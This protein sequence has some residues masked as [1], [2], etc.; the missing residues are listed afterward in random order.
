MRF[1]FFIPVALAAALGA[2]RDASACSPPFLSFSSYPLSGSSYPA[3]AALR[4]DSYESDFDLDDF[5]VLV[6]DR[7]ARLVSAESLFPT[8]EP[9]LSFPAPS[10]ALVSPEP[11]PGQ[12]VV[13]RGNVCGALTLEDPDNRCPLV[14][15][16]YTATEPDTAPPA[17]PDFTYTFEYDSGC[18]GGDHWGYVVHVPPPRESAVAAPVIYLLEGFADATLTNRKFA[19]THASTSERSV[20][21]LGSASEGVTCVRVRAV[22]LAGHEAGSPSITCDLPPA[23]QTESKGDDDDDDAGKAAH[24]QGRLEDPGACQLPAGGPGA[25]STLWA[26]LLAASALVGGALRRR[27]ARAPQA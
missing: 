10:A 6:N 19:A 8:D 9:R 18:N 7:P 13:L 5:E 26:G 12:R 23:I 25:R 4:F 22:D 2:P 24:P 16:T 15:I 1:Y 17:I 14:E 11:L 21:D 20:I 3:N 27:R